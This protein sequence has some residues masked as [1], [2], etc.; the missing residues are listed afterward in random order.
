MIQ[1]SH[2]TF[3]LW[4]RRLLLTA[5]ALL[6]VV[7]CWAPRADAAC[8]TGTTL[9]VGSCPS[10]PGP[11]CCASASVV[12]WCEGGDW[13][14]LDCAANSEGQGG[15]CQVNFTNSCCERCA[16]YDDAAFCQCDEGCE[17]WEDCCDD[18]QSLCAET[19]STYC[20]WTVSATFSGYSCGALP[21]VEP[22]GS[23]PYTCGSGGETDC[24]CF[25][26]Q[27]GDDGCGGSCGQC[28]AGSFCDISGMCQCSGTCLGKTCGDDGCGNS[29]GVCAAGQFC[30]SGVC[31]S[32]CTPDCV[33]KSCGD[34]GCGGA[35]GVCPSD[36]MCTPEGTC[37]FGCQP[38]CTGKLCGDD[39]CGGSCGICTSG[40]TC[41]LAGQCET[42]CTSNCLG[43]Q[44]GDDGCG[45][46]CGTCPEGSC[47]ENL[48]VAGC[49]GAC[50]G[51]ECGPD[52]CGGSCGGCSTDEQCS[53]LGVCGPGCSPQCLGRECGNDG[54]GGSCGVC[55]TSSYCGPQGACIDSG[56]ADATVSAPEDACPSGTYWNAL[57]GECVADDGT[58]LAVNREAEVD[59]GCG[60]SHSPTS[61]SL[62]FLAL[63]AWC[64]RSRVSFFSP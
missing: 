40:Q 52:G 5:A 33:G 21:A 44:C 20:S 47:Q 23:Y 3:C 57:V 19:G 29:C 42:N 1:S 10:L 62:V 31:E 13:C 61:W 41:T 55:D 16:T 50:G 22:T 25:N 49:I 14:E 59:S 27:C 34:D 38:D 48:C 30:V 18:Y 7:V 12:Q 9:A 54:C 26:K 35:C 24:S 8:S 64:S 58:N 28:V 32:S 2:T 4:N 45:G 39:G 43:K 17:A 51:K 6:A 56:S 63:V 15:T 53:D 11:G 46:S 36:Q 60:G 37:V